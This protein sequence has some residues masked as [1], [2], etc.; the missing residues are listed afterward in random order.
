MGTL[1][2]SILEQWQTSH[3]PLYLTALAVLV[4][5]GFYLLFKG[6]DWL[7]DGA[8]GLAKALGVNP[9][10]IG[11]T[12]V[13]MA[14]SAPELF[15]CLTAAI[16]GNSDL[17]VGNLVGSNLANIGLVLGFVLL[18]RPL[19][20]RNALPSWQMPFLMVCSLAFAILCL[21]PFERSAFS[22]LD[23]GVSI[24]LMLFFLS[25]LTKDARRKIASGKKVRLARIGRRVS[26]KLTQFLPWVS[27]P[28]TPKTEK[29]EDAS[30]GKCIGLL[31]IAAIILWAGSE[32][33]VEGSIGLAREAGLSDALIGLTLIA[34]G[35]S[36]PELAASYRLALRDEHAILLGNIVGSNIFNI[37]LVG[38]ITGLVLP[39]SVPSQ[40]F[41]L[42]FPAMV[43]I[44]AVLW[45]ILRGKGD[46]TKP[47]GMLLLTIYFATIIASSLLHTS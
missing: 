37:L 7:T 30:A 15:T 43:L 35:T 19:K 41:E 36:L 39:F 42:E 24:L 12:V 18:L 4:I 34:I 16:R 32:T 33:L 45:Y 28:Q 17:V 29:I 23:G 8:I 3:Y 20:S 47:H 38:G 25:F 27:R 5:V 6:G 9:V 2:K 44:T 26:R 22:R 21:V 1:I 14:T 11:L 46:L 13:S 31:I 40:M 10:V